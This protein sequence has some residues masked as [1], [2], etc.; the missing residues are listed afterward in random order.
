LKK[1]QE[2]TNKTTLAS[3]GFKSKAEFLKRYVPESV[4][5]EMSCCDDW[6]IQKLAL[7]HEDCPK[8]IKEYFLASQDW[9]KRFVVLFSNGG[10]KWKKGLKDP[11]IQIRRVALVWK[12]NKTVW[13]RIR[14]F[15]YGSKYKIWESK[16]GIIGFQKSS[17]DS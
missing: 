9:Y 1:E 12:E 2:S 10:Y 14:K 16:N 8:Q 15:F 11:S 13:G 17:S 4:F 6:S 7:T 5:I 3:F